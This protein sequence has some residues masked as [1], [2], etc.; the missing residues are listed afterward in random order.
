MASY[1]VGDVVPLSVTVRDAAGAAADATAVV[2]TLTLPD[3]TTVTPTVAHPATGS[4]TA[5]YPAASAGLHGVSWVATGTNASAYRDSFTVSDTATPLLALDDIKAR[6]NTTQDTNDEEL[7]RFQAAASA[8][9]AMETGRV[10]APRL[11]VQTVDMTGRNS[12]V[13]TVPQPCLLSISAVTDGGVAL[14]SDE[15]TLD[16]SGQLL[17]RRNATWTGEVQIS[18]LAGVAGDDLVVA[19]QA[20]L[21]LLAHL[22]ETQRT[23]AGR[24]ALAGPVP[25]M[26]YA[27]PNRVTEMLA[28]LV[29]PGGFA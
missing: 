24:N 19:Q 18:G 16:R 11:T 10:L 23:P 7:R 14:A 22:W 2:L 4:Y 9:I 29:V 20:T 12:A 26:G 13:L 1:D 3:G 8:R 28:P 17:T 5:T 21:E 15:W 25:G 27:L 6:L